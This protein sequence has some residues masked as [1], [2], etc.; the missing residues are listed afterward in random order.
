MSALSASENVNSAFGWLTGL[1]ICRYLVL[2]C[3]MSLALSALGQADRAS[4]TGLVADPANRAIV[5]V[6]IVATNIATSVHYPT[7]SNDQGNY[8]LRNLPIGTYSVLY[9]KDGF[10][11]F[12]RDGITLEI[13]QVARL[14][15]S[16]TVGSVSDTATVYANVSVL[17]TESVE[18]GTDVGAEVFRDMPQNVYG[19]RAID[20]LAYAYTPTVEGGGWNSSVGGSQAFTK[21]VLL[22]GTS[23]N[24]GNAGWVGESS[25]S[26]E[27]INEFKI[28]TAGISAE[29]ART[30]GGSF[31][32][33]MK[34]GT[35]DWHGSAAGFMQNEFLN[36]NS[37]DNKWW[38]AYTLAGDPNADVSWGKR[39]FDRF[40]DYTG[41][42]GGPIRKNKT[43]FYTTWEQYLQA[44]FQ[45]S[46]GNATVPTTAMLNGDFSALLGSPATNAAGSNVYDSAG[47]MIYVGSIFD[48]TNGDVFVGNVIPQGRIGAEAQ[49]YI[50]I[51]KTYYQPTNSNLQGNFPSLTAGD[52][53]LTQNQFSVKIDQTLSDRDHLSASWT[54]EVRTRPSD[55]FWNSLWQSGSNSDPGPFGNFTKQTTTSPQFRVQDSFAITPSVLNVLSVTWAQEND[56]SS[57][58]AGGGSLPTSM[59]FPTGTPIVPDLAFNGAPNGISEQTTGILWGTSYGASYD[60]AENEALSWAKGNHTFK[61]GGE[62]RDERTNGGWPGGYLNYRFSQSTGIPLSIDPG[63]RGETGFPFANFELGDVDSA[64]QT[65]TSERHG[66][67]YSYSLFFEDN[68]K[69]T[70]NLTLD[71]SLR[72]DGNT[73]LHE[74]NGDWADFNPNAINPAFGGVKGAVTFLN[75]PADSFE[76]RQNFTQFGPHVGA[77]YHLFPRVVLRGSIGLYYAPQEI[78]GYQGVPYGYDANAFEGQN[79]VNSLGNDSVTFNWDQNIY[80]GV[81]TFPGK[82]LGSYIPGSAVVIDPDTLTLGRTLNMNFGAQYEIARDTRLEVSYIGTNGH[83]LHD[84]TL[85]PYYSPTWATYSYY[86]NNGA[87]LSAWVTD[88]ASAAAAG[89]PYPYPGFVGHAYAA[90]NLF[91]QLY[92]GESNTNITWAGSPIGQSTYNAMVAEVITKH[93][94][95]LTFDFNYTLQSGHGNTQSA[96]V[97]TG[98][99]NFQNYAFQDPYAYKDYA[100]SPGYE[101]GWLKGYVMYELPIGRGKQFLSNQRLLEPIIGGWEIC[102]DHSYQTGYPFKAPLASSSAAGSMPG[103]NILYANVAPHANFRKTFTHLN[104]AWGGVSSGVP[105]PG[106]AFVDTTQFSDPAPGQLG[107]AP[108]SFS[109]W[110]FYGTNS[111]D[112]SFL[113][114]QKFGADGKYRLQLRAEFFDL[115][116]RH[117]WAA[118]GGQNL[119]NT[120]GPIDGNTFGHIMSTTGQSRTGQLGARFDF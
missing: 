14:D 98:S 66:R 37:Y 113:K 30:G 9:K 91:P 105:D 4:I 100:R 48:P 120:V 75:S 11:E 104:E 77:S 114:N 74:L 51:Y 112:A 6:E 24:A 32:F 5:G 18:V 65:L 22:D 71:Y 118:P 109:N 19:G 62:L 110:K 3:F 73:P 69:A 38:M 68:F 117:H 33:T 101:K 70:K 52:P 107:N 79:Q 43:F 10:A 13:G 119:F 95:G 106:S 56:D 36:A 94:G 96:F 8:A 58:T 57:I 45:R 72:W 76:T 15:I 12:K 17:D 23:M 27:A 102:S 81:T 116:N 115:F 111:E 108:Y 61:I 92:G 60:L 85:T 46:P 34:S 54:E 2:F 25:P 26:P 97:E 42:V 64:N 59:G 82:N 90:I 80:P 44:D 103:W 49:Q 55:I 40:W 93:R 1:N 63:V 21:Q 87:N 41:G 86:L 16:L 39:G 89:V 78:N 53:R 50:K 35:N 31:E 67:R 99:T 28:D 83:K 88:Q 20:T 47:N 29:S 7:V 84:G